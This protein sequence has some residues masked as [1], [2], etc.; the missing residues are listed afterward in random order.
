MECQDNFSSELMI[1]VWL[2]ALSSS[3]HVCVFVLTPCLLAL[4]LPTPSFP[5]SSSP[6]APLQ[7]V[8]LSFLFS[9][10]FR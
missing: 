2:W 1:D 9:P 5:P 7:P 4:V 10:L 8:P 3:K 6:P